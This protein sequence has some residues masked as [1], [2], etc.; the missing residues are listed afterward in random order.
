[1]IVIPFEKTLFNRWFISRGQV[2][3]RFSFYTSFAPISHGSHDYRFIEHRGNLSLSPA[4]Q[5]FNF[6]DNGNGVSVIGD[7]I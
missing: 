1:M 5:T 2:D 4:A 7:S 3:N 6:R